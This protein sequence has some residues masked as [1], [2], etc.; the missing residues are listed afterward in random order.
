MPGDDV[1]LEPANK[2][3]LAAVSL[4]LIAALV[5]GGA[6]AKGG[7]PGDK[8][9]RTPP[10]TP[11]KIRVISATPS[12]I[13]IAWTRSK[14]N[15]GVA[16]YY[17]HVNGRRAR[18]F[19]PAYTAR[20]L[21][22]NDKVSVRV[23][24][25]DRAGNRSSHSKASESTAACAA[26]AVSTTGSDAKC[27][28][29]RL[30]KPCG[31]I[32]RAYQLAKC[33]DVIS[34]RGGS[35]PKQVIA[36][37]A[38]L[39]ACPSNVRVEEAAGEAVTIT[40]IQL[41]TGGAGTFA[42]DGPDHLYFKGFRLTQGFS[43]ICDANF[44]TFDKIDGGA[45]TVG[46]VQHWVIKNSDFGPCWS[47]GPNYD[48]SCRVYHRAG[49]A[50]LEFE[51]NY[52]G[53]T[54]VFSDV[55]FLNNTVHDFDLVTGHYECMIGG[56]AGAKSLENLVIRGNKFWGC[57][58]YALYLGYLKNVYIENNW[59]G[60]ADHGD[61]APR[62]TSI[63]LSPNAVGPVY[64]RFNSFQDAEGIF[65]DAGTPRV[66]VYYLIGNLFGHRD[67]IA[68]VNYRYNIYDD[69]Q[70]GCG[71]NDATVASFPYVNGSRG[72]TMNY[73]L[74]RRSVADGFVP[75]TVPHSHL[76]T[77]YDRQR[78]GA[79]RTAGSDERGRAHSHRQKP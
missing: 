15:V 30:S 5:I 70:R 41:S 58:I 27:L 19:A 40:E 51:G 34:V 75:A 76:A 4:A 73:H 62:G 29:G 25:Y 52:P 65:A 26:L 23:V 36:E 10:S 2:L 7:R 16:G 69:N 37:V 72:S 32:N 47:S 79:R 78:R 1:K 20:G 43:C 64:I 54:Q 77:D 66:G 46:N 53:A 31:T 9:D 71:P 17:V 59:F 21:R 48:N 33:G 12:S 22:C 11:A 28:R 56:G 55:R 6:P 61:G 60:G 18:V 42:T 8:R 24:A 35:Y 74:A 63:G 50:Q 45:F 44:I 49:A 68:N 3:A 67:C 14:D 13:S 39:S 57:Q 38:R